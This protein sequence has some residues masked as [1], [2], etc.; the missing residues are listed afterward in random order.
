[1]FPP[2]FIPVTLEGMSVITATVLF[3]MSMGM[4]FMYQLFKQEIKRIN[5]ELDR[6]V[7]DINYKLS[8]TNDEV[9]LLFEKIDATNRDI[10][11]IKTHVA[12]TLESVEWMKKYMERNDR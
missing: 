8:D 6:T 5:D 1:M 12:R 4:G 11:E 3:F 9:S 2:E 10:T 7:K